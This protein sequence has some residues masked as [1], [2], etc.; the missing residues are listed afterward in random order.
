MFKKKG[1]ITIFIILGII[2][3]LSAALFFFLRQEVSVFKPTAL[4]PPEIVPVNQFILDCVE[5][6]AEDGANILGA[7]GG[8]IYIPDEIKTETSAY[9]P[10]FEISP[11][12][13]VLWYYRGQ[14]RVPPLDYMRLELVT[15]IEEN[16][17]AC[18]QGFDAFNKTFNITELG[19]ISS[20]VKLGEEDFTVDVNYPLD[21]ILKA[22]EQKFF[23]EDF[24]ISIPYRIKKMHELANQ[25]L[26]R[27]LIS[28]Y[29][30]E[31]TIDFIAMHPDIPYTDMAFSCS[32]KKWELKDVQAKLKKLLSVNLPRINVD[33]T[34]FAPIP[35]EFPYEQNHFIWNVLEERYP[36]THVSFSYDES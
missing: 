23:I 28:K 8:F 27:E 17:P 36:D 11:I 6:I 4:I 10:P 3:L 24:S 1:Q 14:K 15:Y 26:E 33:K 35:D 32:G 13:T 29:F 2:L 12:K 19:K 20:A 30:E 18:L 21:V 5:S 34:D 22:K 9:L 25:I 31:R 7:N 16:L